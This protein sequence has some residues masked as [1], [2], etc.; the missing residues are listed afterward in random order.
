MPPSTLSFDVDALLRVGIAVLGG[1][2]IGIER[3]WSGKATG[4]AARFA[5]VRTFTMLGLVAGLSGWLWT[6]GLTGP[7]LVLLAGLGALVV[8]AYFAASRT[9]IDGTTEV[10]AFVV[11]ASGVIAGAGD[12]RISSALVAITLL[13]LVEKKRLHGWVAALDRVEIR[14]GARFAVM[15]AVVLPLL[16]T[17]PFGPYGGVR[18]RQ[19]WALVLFFSGLSFVGYLARRLAGP[20]RGYAIAGILG[21]LVSSTSVTLTLSRLSQNRPAAARALASGV[22]GANVVLFPRVLIATAVLAPALAAELWLAFV[23][24]ALVGA[25][26]AIHGLRDP[27][28]PGPVEADRNP[29]QFRAAIQMAVLFQG[30]VLAVN[31]ATDRFGAQGLFGSAAVLGLTDVDALTLSMARL[32]TTG[33]DPGTVARALLTGILAN[34]L[35]KLALAIVLGRGRFR[36]LAAAGLSAMAAALAVAAFR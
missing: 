2:A 32:A 29:L 25:L 9:D 7:A 30:V 24:P 6:A 10:A 13:L 19:I 14:A 28:D 33:M 1:L 27:G 26:L 4:P 20:R 36:V 11:L 18:P 35:V 16:P 12:I 5:G 3:Q 15:A 31:F 34:T 23:V 17:G 21:G 8:I 22:L